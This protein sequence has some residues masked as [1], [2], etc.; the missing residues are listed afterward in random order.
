M[1][2]YIT[3][4]IPRSSLL[5]IISVMSPFQRRELEEGEI[6]EPDVW[7]LHTDYVGNRPF[8]YSGKHRFSTYHHPSIYSGNDVVILDHGPESWV[9]HFGYYLDDEGEEIVDD[10]NTF[11]YYHCPESDEISYEMP[12]GYVEVIREYEEERSGNI[13]TSLLYPR[14]PAVLVSD[15]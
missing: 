4:Y 10:R 1:Y 7:E 3:P 8:Y 15:D 13:V 14:L 12:I 5:F 6:Y 2:G 9:K 11:V